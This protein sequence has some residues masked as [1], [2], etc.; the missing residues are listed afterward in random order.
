MHLGASSLISSVKT[1]TKN[2]LKNDL[3]SMPILIGKN[4]KR[5]KTFKLLINYDLA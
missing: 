3:Y 1:S 2:G 4:G 5:E